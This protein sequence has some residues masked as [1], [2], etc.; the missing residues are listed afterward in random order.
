MIPSGMIIIPIHSTVLT[1][2]TGADTHTTTTTTGTVPSPGTPVTVILHTTTAAMNTLEKPAAGEDTAPWHEDPTR[3]Q[4]P[5]A[6]QAMPP[7]GI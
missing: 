7:E 6:S 1:T 2:H 4:I 5:G 3:P